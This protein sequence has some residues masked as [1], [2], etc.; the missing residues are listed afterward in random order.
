MKTAL[1]AFT[2]FLVLGSPLVAGGVNQLQLQGLTVTP[3]VQSREMRY[4]REPDF[5]LGARVELFL[6]NAG[7]AELQLPPD[8]AIQLRGKSPDELLAA[9]EWAWH[10]F[11]SAWSNLP[12]VLPSGALTVWSFNGKR[13]PW[14]AGTSATLALGGTEMPLHF[15]EPSAWLSAVTFLGNATNPFPDSLIFH[16][17]NETRRAVA[18]RGLPALAATRQRIV[19]RVTAAAVADEPY[20]VSRQPKHSC[21]R[22]R[23][24]T[25]GHRQSAAHLHRAGSAVIAGGRAA[26]HALGPPAH[27]ARGI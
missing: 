6:C 25:R 12:L 13:A 7:S 16:V 10:D 17:A 21:R 8:A 15:A 23:G 11:P 3:H 4:R 20:G 19:P 27:Q 24:C 18:A 5:S 2:V 22:P 26:A 9:D 14:G 1:L